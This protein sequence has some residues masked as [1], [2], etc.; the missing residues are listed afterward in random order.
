MADNITHAGNP[1]PALG[2][3]INYVFSSIRAPLLG[4]ET[5]GALVTHQRSYRM[6]WTGIFTIACCLILNLHMAS[7]SSE[8]GWQRLETQY[9]T[10]RYQNLESLLQF[11]K[12]VKFGLSEWRL[13]P[14]FSD[15]KIALRAGLISQ[16]ID[17]IFQR[18]QTILGMHKKMDKVTINVYPNRRLLEA[19]YKEMFPGECHIPAW[20]VHASGT[21]YLSA[22]DINAGMLAHELAHAV[23]DSYLLL[24]PPPASAEILARHVDRYI[25]NGSSSPMATQD[26]D[27]EDSFLEVEGYQ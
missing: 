9:T 11:E 14:S 16:K 18:V 27:L 22:E 15:K 7:A 17:G 19:S 10:V 3:L 5:K 23:I 2:L 13:A 20:Y 25:Q 1:N 6:K 4:L 26:H 24:R 12:Q 8:K 21:V